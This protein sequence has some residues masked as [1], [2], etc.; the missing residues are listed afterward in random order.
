MATGTCIDNGG[1][2][3]SKSVAVKIDEVSPS[4]TVPSSEVTVEANGQ[5]GA[6][7]NYAAMVSFSDGSSGLAPGNACLPGSGAVFP[8]GKTTVTCHAL[9]LAGN[10]AT[11]SFVVD[12]AKSGPLSVGPGQS[13]VIPQGTVNGP[14]TVQAGGSLVV[15]GA[16]LN[17]PVTVQAGGSLTLQGAKLSGPLKV[18]G[19]TTV[20]VCGATF[21]G[22]VSIT[23]TTGLVVVGD[24]G[25]A[26][27][28]DGNAITGPATI[29]GNHGGVEFD[30][31]T[32]GGPLTITGNTGTLPPPRSGTV[33]VLGNT[34]KGKANVQPSF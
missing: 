24:G 21:D 31:N 27:G 32:V 19:A 14:V 1:N 22:P 23:G 11:A 10:S 7:V 5:G 16:T 6:T 30:G 8:L 28:C 18:S 26:A 15:D 9:D 33:E 34:V 4:I 12:V 25:G 20:R 29:T 17:G 13:A 2:V 3:V